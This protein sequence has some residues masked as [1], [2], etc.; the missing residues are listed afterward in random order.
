MTTAALPRIDRRISKLRLAL[1]SLLFYGVIMPLNWV[2]KRLGRESTLIALMSQ[3]PMR[4]KFDQVFRRYEPTGHDIFVCTFAKSGT[5]WMMQ[6]AHQIA[7]LGAAEYEHIHDVISWP[8][9]GEKGSRN[10]AVDIGDERVQQASPTH[11]RVIKTHLSARNVPYSEEAR[12]LIVIRDPKEIFVSSYHFAAGAA[13]PIMPQVGVWY[14][15]FLADKFPID[16]G[17]TWAEHTASYWALKDKPNVLVLSFR[18]MKLDLPG[19]V[20]QVADVLGVELTSAQ[21][22]AVIE[23]SSFAYMSSIEDKFSPMPKGSLP[24]GD[25]LKMMRE[26]KAG[27]SNEMLT[28]EQQRQIDRHFQRA[29]KRL[30]SDFPYAEFFAVADQAAEST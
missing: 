7:F 30:G 11:L 10:V 22:N 19:A 18:A 12:Y 13:G 4:R 9:M 15:L 23:K 29:L 26:G 24:W 16:F 21:I 5:N 27:N 3:G 17:N 2:F 14:E 6:I 28:A 8:D 1:I 20:R 25:G